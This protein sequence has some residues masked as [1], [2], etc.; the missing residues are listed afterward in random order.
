MLLLQACSSGSPQG[1]T[2][3]RK[4]VRGSPTNL[5][6]QRAVIFTCSEL[7]ST[8]LGKASTSQ[9]VLLYKSKLVVRRGPA[10]QAPPGKCLP[11]RTLS[12]GKVNR[13]GSDAA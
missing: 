8:T 3:K 1:P 13:E 4:V 2:S 6:T 5:L 10:A 9:P 11:R 12:F 7:L